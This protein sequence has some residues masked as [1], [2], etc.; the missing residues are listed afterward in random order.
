MD[1]DSSGFIEAGEVKALLDDVYEGNAPSF[2]VDAFLQFFD[3]NKDGKISWTEFEQ[4]LGAAMAQKSTTP[5]A[6]VTNQLSLPGDDDDE[7][8][9]DDEE[10]GLQIA[11]EVSG[12]YTT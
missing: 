5:T 3:K 1:T 6:P 12:T 11:P 2:E 8:E 10:P 4:G 9:E 7:E